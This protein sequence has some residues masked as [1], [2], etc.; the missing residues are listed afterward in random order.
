MRKI[1]LITMT[2]L[3]L[4]TQVHVMADDVK[5]PVDSVIVRDIEEVVVISTPKENQYLRQQTL[6]STSFSQAEMRTKGVTSIKGVSAM[7]PNLYIPTYG[8]KL[9]TATYIRGIGSRINTPAVG[10][11]VDNIPY[12]NKNAFDFN[13]SDV[14]RVDVL[15]GPQGTLYGR[16]TMGGLIRVFTRSPFD[17]QGTDLNLSAAT[18]GDFKANVTH[19]HRT[20]LTLDSTLCICAGCNSVE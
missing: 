9:T 1:L 8:S 12:I 16:N 10:L 13:F 11:Y 14:E 6:S 17:Y 19:Y 7:V 20:E 5:T 2:A 3:M 15:R 18:Y 4:G